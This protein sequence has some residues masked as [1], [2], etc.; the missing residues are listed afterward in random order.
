[1]VASN[2]WRLTVDSFMMIPMVLAA[3]F[4]LFLFCLGVAIV[5]WVVGRVEMDKRKADALEQERRHQERLRALELGFPLPEAELARAQADTSR[6]RWAGIVGFLVPLGL[7][8]IAVGATA[9]ILD[10]QPIETFSMMRM[11]AVLYAIWG[12]NGLVSLMA[13]LMSATALRRSKHL[14]PEARPARQRADERPL[15]QANR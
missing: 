12:I 4:A 7:A 9:L 6:A 1:M 2:N 8:G 14:N 15:A 3:G 10:H 11:P 13:V 5:G